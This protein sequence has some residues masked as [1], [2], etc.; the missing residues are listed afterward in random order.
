VRA[1]RASSNAFVGQVALVVNLMPPLVDS[2]SS[3]FAVT[4]STTA[5]LNRN[6]E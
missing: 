5:R 1:D 6:T 4:L 2:K 3:N